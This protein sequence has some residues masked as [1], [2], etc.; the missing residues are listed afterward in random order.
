VRNSGIKDSLDSGSGRRFGLGSR[1]GIEEEIVD[2]ENL[3]YTSK[4]EGFE[5]DFGSMWKTRLKFFQRDHKRL[6]ETVNQGVPSSSLQPVELV[7]L[8]NDN[9]KGTSD[10]Q[11]LTVYEQD[12]STL[13]Q[14]HFLLTN[15]PGFRSSSQGIEALLNKELPKR[16]FLTLSFTAYKATGPAS[17][18]NGEFEN[19]TGIAGSL[20]DNPNTLLNARGRLFFDR[21]YLGKLAA[22]GRAPLGFSLGSV[23][24]YSDGLPFGRRLIITGLN[25][26]P[27]YIMATPRGELGGLRTQVNLVF[28]QRIGRDFKIASHKFSGYVDI[29]NLLNLNKSLL[30]WDLSGPLF[31]QRLPLKVMNPRVVRFGFRW[32]F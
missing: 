26:G 15:P 27:F 7:D 19:D 12:I 9:I 10:D 13:G 4:V 30:E 5:Q 22:H 32:N 14:D 31:D 23:I 6:V 1:I 21:A 16:W 11:I 25:Q 8:G 17:P 2:V 29:F 24:R 28:D 20:F 18:G 3:P